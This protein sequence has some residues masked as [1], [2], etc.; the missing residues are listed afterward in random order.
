MKLFT[1]RSFQFSDPVTLCSA[2]TLSSSSQYVVYLQ[3]TTTILIHTEQS[4]KP[5]FGAQ[6]STKLRSMLFFMK[7]CCSALHFVSSSFQAGITL[8][9]RNNDDRRDR[10]KWMVLLVSDWQQRT[11]SSK[12]R[13][14][15]KWS[16]FLLNSTKIHNSKGFLLSSYISLFHY[17]QFFEN[18]APDSSRR[19]TRPFA[20]GPNDRGAE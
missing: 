11:Q 10:V 18:I 17:F 7:F 5:P 9:W 15:V 3:S 6:I 1:R 19:Q 4:K 2:N 20:E 13:C 14:I 16:P 12:R 8:G